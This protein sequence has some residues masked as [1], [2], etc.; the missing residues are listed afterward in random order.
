MDSVNPA[1]SHAPTELPGSKRTAICAEVEAL[2]R[3]AADTARATGAEPCTAVVQALLAFA[4]EQPDRSRLLFCDSL[5]GGAQAR[6]QRDA[7]VSLAADVVEQ[8]WQ[9]SESLGGPDVPALAILGGSFRLLAWSSSPAGA[10]RTRE[11]LSDMLEAWIDS[12]CVPDHT[13][14]WRGL[15]PNARFDWV[16]T[17]AARAT[18]PA[19]SERERIV[20]A[21]AY[22]I[23]RRGYAH[24]S[25][26]EILE[27]AEVDLGEFHLHFPS[28]HAAAMAAL[29]LAYERTI[30]G[31]ARAYAA[32]ELPWG[33]R[34]CHVGQALNEY[35]RSDPALVNL[36]IVEAHALGP[37]A[38]RID[39]DRL[40][41]FTFMLE[42]GYSQSAHALGLPRT[43][44][45]AVAAAMFELGYI[46]CKHLL[47]DS[48]PDLLAQRLYV[49]LAPFL[50]PR[51][52]GRL[53]DRHFQ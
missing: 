10:E 40:M 11:E 49:T 25:I 8:A 9:S 1:Q 30:M 3:E 50:G 21:S 12:Y 38:V 31:A 45:E 26:A 16:P 42:P 53:I 47:A 29:E 36:A 34:I 14:C 23:F 2:V 39:H 35:Y 28:L 18:L 17:A 22:V 7:L 27:L 20:H 19:G 41:A 43:I 24:T 52:A 13:P 51:Q 33:E 4:F 37:E 44:S 48:M 32:A 15:S 46:Q 5:A 6:S